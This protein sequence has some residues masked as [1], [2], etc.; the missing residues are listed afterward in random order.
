MWNK[1]VT[2]EK[3]SRIKCQYLTVSKYKVALIKES[4][5]INR[6]NRALY[7]MKLRHI[8]GRGYCDSFCTKRV[9]FNADSN[10]E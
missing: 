10:N 4:Q 6:A 1:T 3:F 7:W 5:I 8:R 2:Y 9:I